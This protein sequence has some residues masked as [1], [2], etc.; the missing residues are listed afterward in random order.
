MQIIPGVSQQILNNYER[1]QSGISEPRLSRIF[2][3]KTVGVRAEM[4]RIFPN[5]SVGVRTD[6]GT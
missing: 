5:I 6:I 3:N 4:A 1:L 2:P